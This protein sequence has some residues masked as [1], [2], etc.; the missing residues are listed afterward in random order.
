MGMR[1]KLFSR[2][3][4]D[5]A[6]RFLLEELNRCGVDT[7]NVKVVPGDSSAFTLV[8]IHLDGGHSF[9]H[10][11]G[12]NAHLALADLALD[13]L[14]ACDILM[15]QDFGALPALDGLAG[16]FVLGEAKKAGVTTVLDEDM[17]PGLDALAKVLPAVD[18][19][20]PGRETVE[21]LLP[22]CDLGSSARRFQ[23][24][25]AKTVVIKMSKEGCLCLENGTLSAFPSV[26]DKVVDTTGAGDSFD[27]GFLAGL[28]IG[29]STD[30]CIRLASHTAAAKIANVGGSGGIPRLSKLLA[31]A[32][33]TPND[34]SRI[35]P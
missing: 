27:A 26:A 10:T 3:G 16:A 28:T 15:Y 1:P 18:Y 34:H 9:V 29:L 6:G 13:R 22:G 20:L 33:I 14:C 17:W 24:M 11:S 2:L 23:D 7:A 21:R 30:Q 19:F 31:R 25:G 32:G 8:G 35:L 4:D 12:A 5:F